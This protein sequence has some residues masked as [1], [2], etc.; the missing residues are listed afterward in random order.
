MKEEDRTTVKG[1]DWVPV[2][3]AYFLNQVFSGK[4]EIK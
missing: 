3:Y 1:V 4:C 2:H